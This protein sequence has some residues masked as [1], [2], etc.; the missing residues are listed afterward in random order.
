MNVSRR[1][2]VAIL[3][4][5]ATVVFALGVAAE[6]S[7]GEADEH[8]ESVSESVAE[9]NEGAERDEELEATDELS[10]SHEDEETLLGVDIESPALIA[11]AVAA[12]LALAAGALLIRSRKVLVV[13]VVF[14]LLFVLLDIREVL[15]QADESNTGLIVAAAAAGLLHLGAA[16]AAA[17]EVRA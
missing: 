16:A 7:Q 5:L 13:I 10:D 2:I 6:G 9:H 4:V 11:A 14:A 15:H 8:R 17:R 3:L 12:S 1:A